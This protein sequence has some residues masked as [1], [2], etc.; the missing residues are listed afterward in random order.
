MI[1][2]FDLDRTLVRRNASFSFYFYLLR[3]KI[4]P[5]A[6]L[7][8]IIPLYIQ[9]CFNTLSLRDLH[10]RVFQIILQ[11]RSLSLFTE[12]VSPFLDKFLNSFINKIVFNRFLEAKEKGHHT[13]LL[14]SSPGF[15]VKP[16]AERL[17]F[18][19]AQGT[20]YA[21]DKEG[22]LCEISF[23]IEGTAKLQ[24][25]KQFPQEQTIAYT[26]S[27]DDLPLLEWANLSIV[28]NPNRRLKILAE[29]KKWEIL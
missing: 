18:D 10:I 9:R 22:R 25:A 15:L 8:K 20:E 27:E 7:L 28:V 23:L 26:D 19:R 29:K 5:S 2:I 4:L 1:S 16:I 11:G 12:A 3:Q 24:F 6:T 17:G 13:L 21:I 14:S